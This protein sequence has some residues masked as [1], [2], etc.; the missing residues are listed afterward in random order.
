MEGVI[1]VI[2]AKTTD[3]YAK[4]T[5]IGHGIPATNPIVI[6]VA[7]ACHVSAILPVRCHPGLLLSVVID[8]SR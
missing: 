8:R 1:C 7:P 6:A 5:Q 3:G 4:L 2:N